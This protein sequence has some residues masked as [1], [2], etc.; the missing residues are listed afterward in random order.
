MQEIEVE[1]KPD[2]AELIKK[3]LRT[4]S[5]QLKLVMFLNDAMKNGLEEFEVPIVK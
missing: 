3:K 4:W 5:R 2:Y 1:L